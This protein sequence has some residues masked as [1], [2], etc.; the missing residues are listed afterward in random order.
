MK[1]FL[2]YIGFAFVVSFASITIY[3]AVTAVVE[4]RLIGKGNNTEIDYYSTSIDGCD[5][6]VLSRFYTNGGG[7]NMTHK[8]NCKNPIHQQKP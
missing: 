8:G 6:I 5:Y 3:A 4:E 1:K 7:V 2:M